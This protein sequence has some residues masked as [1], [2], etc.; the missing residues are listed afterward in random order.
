MPE[1]QKNIYLITGESI[2]MVGHSPFIEVLQM[3]KGFEVLFMV[4]PIDEYM[5]QRRKEYNG[6]GLVSVTQEGLEIEENDT[7]RAEREAED[8]SLQKLYLR[9]KEIL[10]DRIERLQV[11]LRISKS[12][13]VLLSGLAQTL[14]DKSDRL[15]SYFVSRKIMELN[16]KHAVVENLRQLVEVEEESGR[17]EGLVKDLVQLMFDV[18]LVVSGFS[19]EETG[20]FAE[21]IYGLILLGLSSGGSCRGQ[22]S[23]A[24]EEEMP[25][26]EVASQVGAEVGVDA[27]V[28][29]RQVQNLD[30]QMEEVD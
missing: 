15:S 13:C 28:D 4:D 22:G 29:Q 25:G 12:P 3:K 10:G 23:G 26:L 7:E 24:G 2:A 9:I 17:N 19:I 18:A 20:Q 27:A 16:P 14:R 1:G 30:I 6:K 5:L 8:Q 21:R 11:S